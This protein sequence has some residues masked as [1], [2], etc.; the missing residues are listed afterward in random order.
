MNYLMIISVVV[1]AFA[2]IA[3]QVKKDERFIQFFNLLMFATV[4]QLL[5][6][7]FSPMSVTVVYSLIGLVSL[8]FV[9][10][11]IKFLQNNYLRILVPIIS[12]GGF[13]LLSHG[14]TIN[15][16]G[17]DYISV[18]KF[19]VVGTIMAV[20][21]YEFGLI[22]I[23]ALKNLFTGFEWEEIMSPLLLLF[24]GIS[25]FFGSLASSTFGVLVVTSAFLASSFFR[26][27]GTHHLLVSL[28]IISVLPFL[29]SLVD[30]ES[31]V[32][33]DG[34]VI[35]GLFVGAFAMNFVQKLWSAKKQNIIAIGISYLAI[36]FIIFALLWAGTIFYKMGGMDSLLGAL[37]GIALVNGIIGKGYV[38][39]SLF[40][41][42]FTGALVIPSFMVNE[43]QKEFEK[44]I[45]TT[46]EGGIDQDGNV[47][48]PPKALSLIEIA[49]TYNIMSDSSSIQFQ[50]GEE[51]KTKG[52][53]KKVNGTISI[54]DDLSKS[55]LSITLS[56]TDFTTFVSSRDESLFSDDYFNTARFPSMNYQATGFK[57]L[58]ENVYELN[59]DF[60]MLGVTKK[61]KVT[62]QRINID[63]RNVLI[64]DG[65]IDRTLFGMTPD[66]SEGNLVTFNYQVELIKT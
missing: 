37:I 24:T 32:L 56:M 66:A 43:E 40:L 61:V 23:K 2:S 16:L 28:L 48:A 59:G 9:A 42:I 6:I 4:A 12:F 60:T 3:L 33:V 20:L 45:I 50:L 27:D 58:N 25:I 55:S 14:T 53:F 52:A 36:L 63:G 64:G 1:L 41:L 11:Q 46:I 19:L 35:T 57:L 17:E 39:T 62:L 18:N 44:H 31:A 34:D 26:K 22:K 30:G 51:G 38:A 47:I 49:G 10:S 15:F 21:S 54:Y 7:G 13:L 29:L 5:T 8:N 65:E